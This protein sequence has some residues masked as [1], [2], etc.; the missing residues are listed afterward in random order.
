MFFDVI[1]LLLMLIRFIVIEL[2]NK[3]IIEQNNKINDNHEICYIKKM[4][5]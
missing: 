2:I 4:N 3:T 5:R 1:N